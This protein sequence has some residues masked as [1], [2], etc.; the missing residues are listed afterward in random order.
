MT[1][2]SGETHG[3]AVRSVIAIAGASGFIGRAL[4]RHLSSRGHD[5]RRLVRRDARDPSE[6]AWHPAKGEI[7]AAALEG[8]D[9]VINLSG[10]SLDQRWT[11]DV[12]REIRASRVDATALLARTI[13]TMARRPRAFLS[14]SAIGVYGDRGDELLDETSTLGSDFLASVCKDWEAATAAAAQAD[15]R[16]VHLRTGVVLAKDGG[17]LARMLMPFRFGVG[18]KLGSGKQWMSWITRDDYASAIEFLVDGRVAGAVNLVAP[19]P[20]RN[21]DLTRA[22]SHEL[23]R[24]SWVPVPKLALEVLLGEMAD[25]AVLASQRVA[26]R[27]LADAGFAFRSP[28]IDGALASVLA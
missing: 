1:T 6:I 20:V 21:A 26:P 9:V 19:N 12:K 27:A 8:A 5:V 11:D 14:G 7:D 17:A 23:H 15:V 25:A 2:T 22:L 16:V 10:E 28:T 3:P 24:P 13:A 4:V 18:G